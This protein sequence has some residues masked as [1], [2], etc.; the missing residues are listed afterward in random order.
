MDWDNILD[1]KNSKLIFQILLGIILAILSFI[2]FAKLVDTVFE[3]EKIFFDSTFTNYIYTYRNPVTTKIMIYLTN[4]GSY[5]VVILSLL[6]SILLALKKYYKLSFYFAFTVGSGFIANA[7]LKLI[8]QRPRPTY[9]PLIT[10]TD[11]SF[12]SGHA[13]G[14]FIFFITVVYFFYHLTRKKFITII[15][16]IFAILITFIIGLSR[17][18]LGVHYPSDILGGIVAGFL[19]VVGI[20]TANKIFT[21]LKLSKD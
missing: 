19:W 21:L 10:E 17:I 3:K 8:I 4:F 16:L 6:F 9:L 5:G 20:I 12:P 15:L 18:Y 14:S 11:F 2:L 1:N 7:L 13:M